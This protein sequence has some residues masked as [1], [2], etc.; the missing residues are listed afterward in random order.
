[1]S[2]VVGMTSY[3]RRVEVGNTAPLASSNEGW[4]IDRRPQAAGML[5]TNALLR[6]S[7]DTELS[8]FT[9]LTS[10][11]I[12]QIAKCEEELSQNDPLSADDNLMQCK[13][14]LSELLMYRDLSDSIGLVISKCWQAASAVKAVTDAPQLP[15]ALKR[16]LQRIFSSPFMKF[17]EACD[18][19]TK[20]EDVASPLSLPGYDELANELIGSAWYSKQND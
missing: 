2:N 20:I 18:I 3:Y 13:I 16:T 19:V 15:T 6:L 14:T 12:E 4:S 5:G 8:K 7:P 17:E 9:V 1:M 10:K 11:A